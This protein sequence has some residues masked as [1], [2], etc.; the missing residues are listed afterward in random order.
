MKIRFPINDDTYVVGI[1]KECWGNNCCPGVKFYTIIS[2]DGEVY[3]CWRMWGKRD[4]SYGSLYKKR[5]EE[6]WKGE[7]R[8]E[9]EEFVNSAPPSGD[10]CA[11]CNLV[12]VNEILN[13]WQNATTNWK[14]FLI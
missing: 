11:I 4:Y 10:E 13:K 6:I 12:K 3:P 7:R 9:V 8:R 14:E 1:G 2:S 5:F